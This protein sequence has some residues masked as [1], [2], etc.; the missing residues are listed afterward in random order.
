MIRLFRRRRERS[1][2]KG[3]LLRWDLLFAGFLLLV[4]AAP[5]IAQA[6]YTTDAVSLTRYAAVHGR[7]ALLGGN[8]AAGLEGWAYPLQ[9][10]RGLKPSFRLAGAS[11]YIASAPLLRRIEYTPTTVERTYEGADF[12]V[13]ETLFVPKDLPGAVLTYTVDS[14]RPI[15]IEI[16]FVPVLDLMW[17]VA[18]GG[19]EIHW[20]PDTNAYLM[21]E[22]TQRFHA[23][24]GSPDAVLN[25]DLINTNAPL[26]SEHTLRLTLRAAKTVRVV[27]AADTHGA[28]ET[29]DLYETLVSGSAGLEADAEQQERQRAETAMRIETPDAEVNQALAWSQLALDQ[30][31]VCNPTL[32]CGLV[33]GYGPSRGL[34]RRPQYAWFFAGDAL[35]TMHTLL[36][37]GEFTRSRDALLFLMRYQDPHN[38]MMWHEMSQSAS[39]VNWARDYPYM[40]PH[41]DITFQFLSMLGE[42]ANATSDTQFLRD[43]WSNIESSYRYCS[44]LIDP[45]DGLPKV[46]AGKEG[47][48]EQGHP[49][50]ELELAVSWVEAS[51]SFANLAE[52]TGHGDLAQQAR[53]ATLRASTVIPAHFWNGQKKFWS[54]GIL[55]NGQPEEAMH[56]PPAASLPL[57]NSVQ[58]DEVLDRIASPEF[59]TA[60]GT[61]GVGSASK[62]FDPSSYATGSVWA[63]S[64][65]TAALEL[66]QGGRPDAAWKIW[67]TLLP[68]LKLDAMG[69]IH[70]TLSGSSFRPQIESVPEQTWSSAMFVSSFLQGVLGEQ[71]DAEHHRLTLA[72]HL[73]PEW[74]DLSVHRLRIGDTTMDVRVR[75]SANRTELQV[76]SQGAPIELTFM[77]TLPQGARLA[78]AQVDQHRVTRTMQ[79]PG[80][81]VSVP[82]LLRSDGATHTVSIAYQIA[83]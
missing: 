42:Y 54:S 8:A 29:H 47:G 80:E 22:P 41:V 25:D 65:A 60:W 52:L 51:Q 43:H 59:E 24:I 40:F 12:T 6:D 20:S 68:W 79:H 50:E 66:W 4:S 15:Q 77:P 39:Y 23:L 64:T 26:T 74:S 72:P 71:P 3:Q 37:A 17:P 81:K 11:S 14:N 48:D 31:W 61:R 19:Q 56:L 13:K 33:A 75:R 55:E 30:A 34:A 69:H 63:T 28:K 67:S 27:M 58:E 45:A 73:P 18:T 70:E 57:L 49:R 76:R 36:L 38:G 83:R 5:V 32:G 2:S 44:S 16:R 78:G 62:N 10:F 53:T 46:P 35:T 82:V 7:M 1:S 9:I 21:D